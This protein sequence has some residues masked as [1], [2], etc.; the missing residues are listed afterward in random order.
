MKSDPVYA[1]ADPDAFPYLR[2]ATKY[3]QQFQAL[4]VLPSFDSSRMQES[5]QLNT[6]ES[7]EKRVSEEISSDAALKGAGNHD[8]DTTDDHVPYEQDSK[9]VCDSEAVINQ[10]RFQRTQ[11]RIPNFN[12]KIVRN[13][14]VE[15]LKWNF[16]KR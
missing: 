1:I 7:L 11:Y 4:P 16:S 13:F 9:E 12:R 8:R 3:M 14:E 5:H 10:G 15:I 2:E 6:L